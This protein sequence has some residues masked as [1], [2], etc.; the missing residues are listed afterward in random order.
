MQLVYPKER[1]LFAIIVSIS[2]LAW[3]G[4]VAGTFGIALLYML[5]F[6]V[7]Y[8]FAQSGFISYVRG[9]GVEISPAQFPELHE[10]I[11]RC[12]GELGMSRVPTGYVLNAH[13]LLNALATRFLRRHYVVLFSDVV[14]ALADRP[15]ALDFYIGHE[16]GHIRRGHLAWGWFLAP[17]RFLPLLGTAYSRA[18]EYTCDLHGLACCANPQDAAFGLAVLAAGKH[19]SNGLDLVTFA[20][21]SDATGGFWMSFHELT[22]DYP[23]LTK[24]MRF[25][26]AQASRRQPTFPRRHPLAWLLAAF[27]PR[28]G[29]AGGGAAGAMMTVAIV[30]VVAAVAMPNFLR[31]QAIS[32]LSPVRAMRQEIEQRTGAFISERGHMPA[33]L[34]DV[35]MDAQPSNSAVARAYV[36]GARVVMELEEIANAGGSTVVLTPG[37]SPSGALEWECE[38]DVDAAFESVVCGGAVAAEQAPSPGLGE[39]FGQ[40]LGSSSGPGA[41]G[42][43]DSPDASPTWFVGNEEYACSAEFKESDGFAKLEPSSRQRLLQH[44]AEWRLEN[45]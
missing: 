42:A 3:L 23:W 17:G 8:L 9:T 6:W 28:M 19:G 5:F 13:G 29:A 44:C 41:P 26:L 33:T 39:L 30:G 34:A 12:C 4:L 25:L 37:Y 38:T 14:D 7:G 31:F 43:S 20:D 22:G 16:L 36:D 18:R 2:A 21:Q 11:E 40:L 32:E 10:R 45:L 15:D 35:G 1:T 24:R 27:V